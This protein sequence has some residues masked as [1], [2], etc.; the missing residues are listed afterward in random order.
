MKMFNFSTSYYKKYYVNH[1]GMNT[2]VYIFYMFGRKHLKFVFRLLAKSY[3]LIIFLEKWLQY[4][5]ALS[6]L[7]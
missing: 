3:M 7:F 1:R 2:N 4:E 6:G 5:L